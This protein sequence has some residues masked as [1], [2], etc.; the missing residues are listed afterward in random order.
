[1]KLKLSKETLRTLQEPQL[2]NVRGALTG[3]ACN[4][5]EVTLFHCW[6]LGGGCDTVSGCFETRESCGCMWSEPGATCTVTV[7]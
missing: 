6:S 2:V 4:L 1:M 7:P 3:L 5:T